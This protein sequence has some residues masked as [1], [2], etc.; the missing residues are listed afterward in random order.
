MSTHPLWR[1][2]EL[3][4]LDEVAAVRIGGAA[5]A[6]VVV[7]PPDPRWPE[8]YA[9]LAALVRSALGDGVL[10]LEHVGSTAV[11][12]LAAKPVVDADL[13]V[14][15]S[16]DEASYV[17]ALEAVGFSLRVREP[18]WEEHR[19]LRLPEG[20][21]PA[22]VGAPAVN[23]H[24]WSPGAVEPR[25]HLLFRDHLRA[26]PGARD[27]YAAAKAGAAAGGH[28]EAMAYNNDKAAAVYD[29]Y[30]EA[31][32]ADPAHPHTPHPR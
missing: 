8:A 25:R 1:P 15:D 26:D 11:P 24:V 31:F 6:P 23:L 14:A 29:L 20:V 30:E 4:D 3:A 16:G 21:L 5:S 17:P 12:G 10:A 28:T 32:L 9:A 27:R 22:A 19:V 13:T 18:E 7:V 2:F